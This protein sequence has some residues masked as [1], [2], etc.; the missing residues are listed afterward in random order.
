[1][2]H[3]DKMIATDASA[4]QIASAATHSKIEYRVAPAESSGLEN[5][6]VD[7]ITVAQA[8][9]WFDIERFFYEAT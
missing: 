3:F 2:E 4:E 9:H 5:N 7:L 6:S 1:M 8:L